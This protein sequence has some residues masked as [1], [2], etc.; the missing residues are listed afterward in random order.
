MDR[1]DGTGK[2]HRGDRKG[3]HGKG[4]WGKPAEKE[5]EE[6]AEN[7]AENTEETKE[8]KKEEKPVEVEPEVEEEE[9]GFTYDDFLAQKA[10]NNLPQA[11]AREHV[12]ITAN[13][14][15]AGDK[16]RINTK[17]N[18]IAGRDVYAKHAGT[19]MDLMGF[20]APK[21]DEQ[22]FDR[23]G[24][25]PRGPANRGPRPDNRGPREQRPRG[26]RK[27]G[28]IVVDDNEFPAL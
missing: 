25:G 16:E 24:A 22:S 20:T 3:G 15:I 14:E 28:K 23:R 11:A 7:K 10:G 4:N 17:S 13:V 2:A 18:K 8:E 12:K 26:G 21:D 19:G 27:G 5:G 1:Q 9:E 6:G